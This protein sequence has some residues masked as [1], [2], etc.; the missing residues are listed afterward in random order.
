MR[1][2]VPVRFAERSDG[3]TDRPTAVPSRG[4]ELGIC[5]YALE[6]FRFSRVTVYAGPRPITYDGTMPPS[7]VA[8]ALVLL[9]LLCTDADV[10]HRR[11]A[12]AVM[13]P[14]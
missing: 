9:G 13:L 2:A 1:A 7:Q 14:S 5:T 6:L 10:E 3:W 12:S 11:H 4:R 8:E